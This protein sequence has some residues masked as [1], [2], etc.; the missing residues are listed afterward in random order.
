MTANTLPAAPSHTR[1][2]LQLDGLRAI[3]VMGVFFQHMLIVIV[4]LWRALATPWFDSYWPIYYLTPFRMDLLAAGALLAVI[5]RRD[6]NALARFK[7][8]AVVGALAALAVLAWLHLHY[9]LIRHCPTRDF[10]AFR[11]CFARQWS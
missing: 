10:I 4:P 9:P 11:G 2:I 1:R 7:V 3:A 8:L 5:V 6:A